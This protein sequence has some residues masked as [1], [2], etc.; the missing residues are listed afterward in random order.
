MSKFSAPT[1]ARLSKAFESWGSRWFGQREAINSYAIPTGVA[2]WFLSI[3]ARHS[4]EVCWRKS[5]GTVNSRA[6]ISKRIYER[7]ADLR[8]AQGAVEGVGLRS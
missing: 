3:E 6:A 7:A 8:M 1:G 5:F 4:D 2:Q